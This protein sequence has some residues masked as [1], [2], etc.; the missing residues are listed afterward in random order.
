M[1]PPYGVGAHVR[2]RG[3]DLLGVCRGMVRMARR[4]RLA[5]AKP[6]FMSPLFVL[7][8]SPCSYSARPAAMAARSSDVGKSASRPK[9]SAATI[10]IGLGQIARF[11]DRR[12]K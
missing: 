1:S 5:M 3:V 2:E 7:M 6:H 10:L 4:A 11:L 8:N 9:N 12:F